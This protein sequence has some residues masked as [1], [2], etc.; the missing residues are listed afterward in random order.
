MSVSA[1]T[2][3]SEPS[4]TKRRDLLG[5]TNHMKRRYTK[6][7]GREKR[8]HITTTTTCFFFYFAQFKRVQAAKKAARESGKALRRRPCVGICYY[9]KLRGEK[10]P[11]EKY[12][13]KYK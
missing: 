9:Y 4:R 1:I 8:T 7:K 2:L 3:N 6:Q 10:N 11:F 13:R 12:A 5:S